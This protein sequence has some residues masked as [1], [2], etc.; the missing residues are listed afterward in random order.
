MSNLTPDDDM[1]KHAAL[2]EEVELQPHQVRAISRIK[3][4]PSVL[5]YHGLGSGK[6]LS[7][8]A[9]GE[10]LGGRKEVIVPASLRENYKKELSKFVKGTPK[11][12]DIKSYQ[13][14]TAEGLSPAELTIFDEAHRMG[15]AGTQVSQ[16]PKQISGKS[17]FLTGTP[18]RNEPVELMPLL[19]AISEDRKPPQSGKAFEDT[20]VGSRK[21]SPGFFK[22]YILGVRPGSE[23]FIKNKAYLSRLVRG[24]VDYHAAAGEYPTVNVEQV[25]VEMTPEQSNIY[26]ALM[27]A[28]PALAYK[29]RY[30]L[31]PSKQESRGLNAFL[32][33]VRQVSNN[34]QSYDVT[35]KGPAIAHSPKLQRVFS[36]LQEGLKSNKNFKALVYS[37]YLDS[38]VKPLAA[39]LENNG[40]PYGLFTG[41]LNDKQR[42]DLVKRYNNNSI[43]VL[44][45]SGAGSEGLDL[46][47]TRMVQLLEPHWN[48]ARL[49]QVIG[50]AVRHRSH[51]HLPEQDRNVT[52]R[53]YFATPRPGMLSRWGITDPDTGADRYLEELSNRKQALIEEVLGVL[54]SVGSEAAQQ[55]A[56]ADYAPGL[57]D[58]RRFGREEEITTGRE[59]PYVVQRHLA[60]R[61][62]PH[63]DMR[64]GVRPGGQSPLLSFATK[65]ELPQPAGRTLLFQQPL[66]RG[67]YANFEGE[68]TSGYG[69]G[70]VKTK[71][72]G[73]IIVTKAQPGQINFIVAH[74][75]YPEFYTLKR[76][77]A[78]PGQSTPRQVR[79]QGGTWL[80][81]N[82]TP[83]DAAKLLGGD[84]KSVGL[85]KLKYTTVPAE[86]VEKIFD[87]KYLVQE[88]V[89]GASALYHLLA[90]R[91]NVLSYRQSKTGRPII[92]TY[93]VLGPGGDKTGVKIPKELVGTILRGEIYGERKGKAIPPQELG[94][95]L[96]ASISNSLKKQ[97]EQN[98]TIKNMLFD[99]VRLGKTPVGPLGAEERLSK[100][101]EIRQYLPKN[102]FS[103]P[104]TA[105]TAEAARAL[106]QRIIS[107]EHPRTSEGVIAWPREPGRPIKVKARPESDVWIK[108]VFP[109][110][111][112]LTG[113]GAGGFEYATSPEGEAVGRVGTGFS[114]QTRQ[115]MLA[116][117]AEW[118]GRM[119]RISSQGRFPGGAHRAPSFLA[120]HEDYPVK[121][122]A[123]KLAK[124]FKYWPFVAGAGTIGA[125]VLGHKLLSEEA[126]ESASDIEP[127]SPYK[128]NKLVE[129]LAGDK[130]L[131]LNLT[132]R[133][134]SK[135]SPLAGGVSRG[136]FMAPEDIDARTWTLLKSWG[137]N[138]SE[139]QKAQ[140]A[141]HGLVI[142]S[143]KYGPA[144]LA[145]ELGHDLVDKPSRLSSNLSRLST[146]AS[147]LASLALGAHLSKKPWPLW[148]RLGAAG[149]GGTAVG[150]GLN[151]PILSEEARASFKAYD[152][153]KDMGLSE[154]DLAS[155][156]KALASTFGM[157]LLGKAVPA[158]ASGIMMV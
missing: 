58:P 141:K 31:P 11:G 147:P 7:S 12:Y 94:G 53:H 99:V 1:T 33:A 126:Q 56:A 129:N 45:V 74:K 37:N 71:D 120:L 139:A 85:E 19:K 151:V 98:A 157:T 67:Q 68:I 104:E 144:P 118:V 36:D 22:Q 41:E 149:L 92:H 78:P 65:K 134:H 54:K 16:L 10:A 38:G 137:M 87:P 109:G 77:G 48:K 117:P 13:K 106:Y 23:A 119:A 96:N 80:M 5:L 155:A 28:N 156:R 153:L 145:Y 146:F 133:R 102:K 66:H 111:K 84:P 110:E 115:E 20:F 100:L 60:E 44:L 124:P 15:R 46:K 136:T 138:L 140:A 73:S 24:R 9:A 72:K 8:I 130:A 34:P 61:A 47:G 18:I 101:K 51:A 70:T 143:Q 127:L 158:A 25:D 135:L 154:D 107:G 150:L 88:K 116:D 148:K 121:A 103:L 64:F 63:Y 75:K 122:A 29:V 128:L 132:D 113:V 93:R 152:A 82:T 123:V 42:A 32:G 69:K 105:E 17:V 142:S 27:R 55:K 79:T 30:N 14:A 95:I 76:V 97:R 50:R 91:I 62:G 89:D 112:G 86:Q 39:E 21:V 108:N 35:M 3:S 52:V 131:Q 2:K 26:N 57:P 6:T 43:R 81:V 125:G 40:I 59:L 49:D 4:E 114:A 83:M 90:D